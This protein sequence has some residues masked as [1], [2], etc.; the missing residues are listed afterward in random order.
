MSIYHNV[1]SRAFLALS[2]DRFSNENLIDRVGTFGVKCPYDRQYVL[3]M[4]CRLPH[5]EFKIPSELGWL[6]V[7]LK[8]SDSYQRNVIGINHPFCYITVR[9]GL[10]TSET[11]DEWHTDGFST[12]ITHLPEQN[13][14]VADSY[15]TE[16]AEKR[17]NFPNDFNP[18]RHNIH[19]YICR[20]IDH[21]EVKYCEAGMVYCLDPYNIHRRQVIPNNV[22]RT[23]VRISYTPIEIMDDANTVNPL[24]KVRRYDR[25]GIKIRNELADYDLEKF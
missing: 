3:R 2:V 11:D 6:R 18:L 24:I 8:M 9:H 17:I 1:K 25:D 13:Y 12:K 19:K 22:L 21:N 10:V 14:I 20:R 16:Y 4:L 15:P 5:E 23:F 7:M